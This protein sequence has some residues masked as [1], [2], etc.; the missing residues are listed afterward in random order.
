MTDRL[1]PG[2]YSA[3]TTEEYHRDPSVEVSL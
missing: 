1:P 2:F 3:L